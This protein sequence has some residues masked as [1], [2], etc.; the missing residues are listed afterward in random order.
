MKLTLGVYETDLVGIVDVVRDWP[1]TGTWLIGLLLLA[2]DARRS[3]IG[4]DVV[5]AMNGFLDWVAL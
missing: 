2:P 1:R 5:T 3:S 4:A